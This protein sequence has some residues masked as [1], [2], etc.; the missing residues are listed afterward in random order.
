MNLQLTFIENQ[1]SLEAAVHTHFFLNKQPKTFSLFNQ[2]FC[3][4]MTGERQAD[5]SS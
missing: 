3:E 4:V 5:P 1:P 2:M